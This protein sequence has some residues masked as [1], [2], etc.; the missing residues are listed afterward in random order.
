MKKILLSTLAFS[1]CLGSFA[2]N[3]VSSPKTKVPN[4]KREYIA[5]VTGDEIPLAGT[6]QVTAAVHTVNRNGNPSVAV[7]FA[8]GYTTYDLQTNSSIDN[9]IY[10]KSVGIAATWTRS[11]SNDLP[12]A[13]RGTG[14]NFNNAGTWGPLPTTRVE[15]DRRGWPSIDYSE[16]DGNEYFVSHSTLVANG[17]KLVKRTPAGSGT[18]AESEL[19]PADDDSTIIFLW[20]RMRIGGPNNNTIHEIDLSL[21]VG[22][23]PGVIYNGMDGA[24]TYSRSQDGGLTWDIRHMLLPD[25][26]AAHYHGM[27]GDGYSIDVNGSTVAI[28][29]GGFYY[30]WTMWKSTDN[31]DTWTKTVI[32]QF[33]IV[34]FDPTVVGNTTDLDGDGVPEIIPVTDG[35]TAIL[36]DNNGLVHCFAGDMLMSDDGTSVNYSYYITDDAGLYVDGILY[37]NENMGP[38]PATIPE[39]ASAPDLDNDGLITLVDAN[40]AAYQTGLTSMPSVGVD[41]SNNIYLSY[42][43]VM[44]GTT[45]GATVPQS[46][47]DIWMIA[48]QDGGTTWNPPYN[49]TKSDFEEDIF[50]SIARNVFTCVDAVWQDDGEPGLA[51]RGDM[52][53]FQNNDIFYDCITIDS[54]ITVGI[55]EIESTTSQVTIFPNPANDFI[56]LSFTIEKPATIEVDIYNVNGQKVDHLVTAFKTTGAQSIKVNTDKYSSGIYSVNTKIGE[57]TY[58]NKFVIK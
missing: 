53:P 3:R 35:S 32:R 37:W 7:P 41:A 21:P 9:R 58:N 23:P 17:V 19:P 46:F 49:T 2:Q 33:P 8:I 10:H 18:W 48:S 27:N 36:V 52:D 34:A 24:L 13:D 26:D 5:P 6:N 30:D 16:G 45:N 15:T 29:A 28:T 47:R 57:T 12:A 38:I 4:I 1:L 22:N 50:C 39:I 56:H 44:E 54:L 43:T 51:V 14:Y 31:G 55:N 11:T 20:P 42:S 25:V 40:P